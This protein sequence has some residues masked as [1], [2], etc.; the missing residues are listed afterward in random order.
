MDAHVAV[1]ALF[2]ETRQGLL[3]TILPQPERW[4]YL[5][6]LANTLRKPV[7]SLQRELSSLVR[8][9]ILEQRNEGRKVYYRAHIE[10]PIYTD[11]RG[12]FEKIVIPNS[13]QGSIHA[14]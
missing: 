8:A 14:R 12:L 6:E 13:T 11:L 3:A 10:S 2:H 7:S 5:T 4:W 9:E 1:S